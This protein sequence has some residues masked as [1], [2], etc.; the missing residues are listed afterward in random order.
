[1]AQQ[2]MSF[3]RH[4]YEE[5]PAETVSQTIG[6]AAAVGLLIGALL[7]TLLAIGYL[8]TSLGE[9]KEVLIGALGG[10]LI[11]LSTGA[12]GIRVLT[13]KLEADSSDG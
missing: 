3:E 5:T 4:P 10:G 8:N 13:R 1:M 11:G 12:T 2:Q 6:L 7:G 9:A